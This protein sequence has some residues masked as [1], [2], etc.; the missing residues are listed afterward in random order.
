[1]RKWA[2]IAMLAAAVAVAAQEA[3]ELEE[4]VVEEPIEIEEV[5]ESEVVE[6]VEIPE[7][8]G[9]I[10]V[11]KPDAPVVA[12]RIADGGKLMVKHGDDWKPSSLNELTTTLRR[13]AVTFDVREQKVGRSG[14]EQLPSGVSATRLFL[15]IEAHDKTPWQNI[16][17]LMMVAAE[18]K[19]YKLELV[20]GEKRML[21]YLPVDRGLRPTAQEPPKTIKTAV[22]ILAREEKPAQWGDREVNRPTEFRYRCGDK[23]FAKRADLAAVLK[24]AKKAAAAEENLK[25]V[26]EVK[27]SHKTPFAEVFA[28]L[29]IFHAEEVRELSF[30]GTSLPLAE[31]RKVETLPYPA[32]AYN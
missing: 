11:G 13:K 26:G 25:V 8:S 5:D 7:P 18:M 24:S 31:Q 9:K 1:M 16:Q 19:C 32:A 30:Y 15:S 14:Y 17:W 28:V 6:E 10:A 29:G 4:E 23:E 2:W 27:A 12:V 22:H 3:P 20:S 21:A